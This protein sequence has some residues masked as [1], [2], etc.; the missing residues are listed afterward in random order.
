MESITSIARHVSR[1]T[2]SLW[3]SIANDGTC[4]L[5]KMLDD[6]FLEQLRQMR[7][8][9]HE[10]SLP[11][12]STF[13]KS[14]LPNTLRKGFPLPFSTFRQVFVE[15]TPV[16]FMMHITSNRVSSVAAPITFA[17][18]KALAP[19]HFVVSLP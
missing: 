2:P 7:F 9:N 1:E 4:F 3:H 18:K 17:A 15:R 16:S 8:E 14:A 11:T 19:R 12:C 5:A 6:V 13:S 10:S